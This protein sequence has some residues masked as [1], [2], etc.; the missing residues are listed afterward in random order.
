M[1]E[2]LAHDLEW[3]ADRSVPLYLR[4]LVST[5][6]PRAR[7]D[8]SRGGSAERLRRRGSPGSRP[9][10]AA[11]PPCRSRSSPASITA[12]SR[13]AAASIRAVELG[14][15]GASARAGERAGRRGRA[16][17][18]T[19]PAASSRST[20]CVIVAPSRWTWLASAAWLIACRRRRARSARSSFRASRRR[21]ERRPRRRSRIAFAVKT[22]CRP[23]GSQRSPAA[24]S[25]SR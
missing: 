3:I 13:I 8:A 14:A 12:W 6:D 2:K 19:S 4:T 9:G 15:G 7:A 22:S 5:G 17:R 1:A 16:R 11:A 23:S 18:R 20:W 24:P 10:S 21:R 25:P